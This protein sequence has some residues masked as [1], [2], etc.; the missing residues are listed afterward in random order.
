MSV[1]AITLFLALL[2][3]GAQVAVVAVVFLLVAARWSPTADR[4]ARALR[5]AVGP[6]ALWLALGVATVATLGSL[7][8]SEM[9]HFLP[10]K[11]CWYQRIAMYP[12][13]PMLGLAAWRR[14][15]A[16]RP[17]A[18]ILA[19]VGAGIAI[20]HVTL[21]RFP[22]LESDFCDPNNPCSL[23]WMRKFGYLTIPGMALSGFALILV[24]LHLARSREDRNDPST[25][26]T[27]PIV[28]SARY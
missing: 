19:V 9:A 26:F 13:V 7:Y 1:A 5:A 18:A 21:E 3:V 6:D 2:A 4:F 23:I 20:Y 17:Y 8:L 15:R 16:V 24:L 22:Q 12:L 27:A 25:D 10:C 14:D 11:L 28:S